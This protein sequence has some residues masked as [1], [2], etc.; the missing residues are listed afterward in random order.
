MHMLA[1]NFAL[2]RKQEILNDAGKA[3]QYGPHR[4]YRKI[5]LSKT[6]GETL[7]L[8]EFVSGEF[9]KYIDNNGIPC[10]SGNNVSGQKA[11]CLSHLSYERSGTKLVVVNIQGSGCRLYD[12]QI[13]TSGLYDDSQ[14]LFCTGEPC[15]HRNRK[16]YRQAQVHN[17]LH[18]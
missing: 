13:A 8:E 1:H 18:S 16:L 4:K 11:Q 6:D 9:V 7:T 3:K 10:V 14:F 17:I 12:P 5:F 15:T 2:Q